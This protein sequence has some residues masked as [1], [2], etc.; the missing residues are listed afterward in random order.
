MRAKR[1]RWQSEQDQSWRHIDFAVNLKQ[2]PPSLTARLLPQ[3]Q[4][5]L[6]SPNEIIDVSNDAQHPALSTDTKAL[7]NITCCT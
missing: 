5:Q 1:E 3:K 4:K 2:T 6:P 7:L